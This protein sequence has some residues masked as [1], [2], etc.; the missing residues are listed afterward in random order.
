[1]NTLYISIF[2][3][4][5][6]VIINSFFLYP[7]LLFFI[8]K[9]KSYQLKKQ[10]LEPK[11]SFLIAAYNE[12]KVIAQRI[13]NIAS[14][15]YDFSKVEVFIGSDNSSDGTNQILL[16]YEKKYEWLHPFISDVRR[17]KAG[18]LNE[19][20][21]NVNN[22]ILI[23]TDA[24]TEFQ[25]DSLRNIL[26]DFSDDNVGGV[27]GKLV[28]VNNE[29]SQNE[30]VE[31]SRYW[32]Y[33]TFIKRVEGENGIL[34]AANGGIFAIRRNLFKEIPTNPAVTDDLFISLS[35]V[36]QGFKF[37]YCDTAIAYENTG[38]DVQA[39][40]R[41][42]VRF[43][44]TNFQTLAY[45]KKMLVGKNLL[46]AYAFFSHK[47]TRW[48]LPWLLLLLLIFSGLSAPKYTIAFTAYVLQVFFYF[49][50][51]IGFLFST[52]K[53]RIQIFSI[54]YFFVVS[55]VAVAKG[56]IRFLRK[57]HSVIWQSTDRL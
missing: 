36:T 33:E 43:S 47:V 16:D 57:K 50:A 46:L 41:R 15:D 34:L 40:Y 52:M 26:K 22:D 6:I 29:S 12:E 18:I 48:F 27:C 11:I 25:K 21:K 10:N 19:L 51:A 39:E 55:N 38:K 44:A 49:F 4:T 8:N 32:E 9:R 24:N 54:P 1:M 3:L 31:E 17:G 13:E 7:I 14:L 35:V 56:L 28:L 20:M 45:Y 53:L 42:K 30:G 5:T 23:F 2:W 37:T